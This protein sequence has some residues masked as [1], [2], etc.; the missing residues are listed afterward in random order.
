MLNPIHLRTLVEVVRLGSF[1]NAANRLGYSPSAVSQQMSALEQACGV[2]LFARTGRS[3][4]PTE[5]AL[6]MARRAEPLF[7][8]LDAVLDSAHEAHAPADERLSVTMYASLAQAVLP[9]VFNDAKTAA[10]GLRIKVSVQNPSS[11]I[12]A[13]THGDS[14]DI[15]FVYRYAGGLTWPATVTDVDFG[16]DPYRIIV[17]KAWSLPRTV[18][19]ELLSELPWVL[20]QP[21]TSDASTI[22]GTFRAAGVHPRVVAYA[23]HFDVQLS[24][25]TSG[26]AAAFVPGVVAASIPD[27]LCIVEAQGMALSRDV[28]ALIASSAPERATR[29]FLEAT[30]RALE[31][32]A[33]VS[34]G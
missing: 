14:P 6:A 30:R 32:S 27:S 31:P 9:S 24:L 34:L 22:A 12:R 17:P 16:V 26:A 33:A 15:A 19:T 10:S 8:E 5:A 25:V 20:H 18:D 11:S 2:P 7:T 1:A 4:N 29:T 28:H 23:D 3:V 13:L 21:G